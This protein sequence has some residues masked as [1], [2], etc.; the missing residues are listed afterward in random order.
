MRRI[1]IIGGGFTGT[2]VAIRL[3][4][5]APTP[6]NI[7]IIEPRQELGG[8]L[9][10][11]G[12][13]PDHRVNGTHELLVLFPDDI[14]HFAR[15]YETSGAAARDPE[16]RADS[17]VR[18]VRRSDLRGYMNDTLQQTLEENTYGSTVRHVRDRA[19]AARRTDRGVQIELASGRTEEPDLIVLAFGGQRPS[20]FRGVT[21]Q[22][23]NHSGYI[24]DP[25]DTE[26]VS[27]ISPDNSVLLVG[28][29]LTAADVLATLSRQ[30]HRGPIK[31]ISRRGLLPEPQG[32][33]PNVAALMQRLASPMPRF[34]ERHGEGLTLGAS[35]RALR[36]DMELASAEG[37][38]LKGPF[39]DVRDAAGWLWKNFTD[40]EKRR[41][42]RHLK[43]WYD[44]NRYRMVPQTGAK[45]AAAVESGQLKFSV[46]RLDGLDASNNRLEARLL[47]RGGKMVREPFDTVINCTGPKTL[48]DDTFVRTMIDLGLVRPDSMGLGF[49]VDGEGRVLDG[50]GN[51]QNAIWAFGLL[52]RGR[53]GDMTAIPQIAVRLHNS[54]PALIGT[55]VGTEGPPPREVV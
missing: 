54:L 13:D 30:G 29:G 5:S 12:N 8:G 50:D 19:V 1:A 28:T 41:F 24:G 11:G 22:A 15:W 25:F 7:T 51:A 40:P 42:L 2:A 27:A 23:R 3:C 44:V 10:Y 20:L 36:Q 14:G 4:A 9:A 47:E 37:R 34:I 21:A 48:S 33:V 45:I 39:D 16:G 38:D 6:L 46:A 26:A 18:Y 17:G 53:F 52:T 43:P 35:V 32:D 31:A 49:D 55:L